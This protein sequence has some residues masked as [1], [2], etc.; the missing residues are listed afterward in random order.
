MPNSNRRDRAVEA[1]T[2]QPLALTLGEPA[3]IGP[4]LAL[5]V[6][7]RRAELGVPTF[8]LIADVA[9]M[10]RRAARLGIDTPITAVEPGSAAAAFAS[11]LP[12]VGNDA[13]A[14]AEPGRPDES[15]APAAVAS[16]RRGVAD[17]MAG[18]AAAIVTNP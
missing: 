2:V 9:F 1:V 17:V 11:A 5:M 7:R 13:S 14:T 15:S 16:I 8:Y 3:G 18:T 4:D 6:W 12:V 10:R